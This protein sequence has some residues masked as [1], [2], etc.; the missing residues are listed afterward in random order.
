MMA[1]GLLFGGTQAWAAAPPANTVIGN[2]AT[3][4]YLD[5]NGVPQ[6]ATSNIV[7][8][9]VQQ[10]G[11][12]NLDGATQT[13]TTVQN[14]KTGAAGSV[15]YAPHVLTNTGNGTDTFVIKVDAPG[16]N[17]AS[18]GALSNISVFADANF[19]GLP[20]ST[21]ALCSVT[22]NPTGTCNVPAQS[23]AGNNGKFGFV[24]AY[25]LPGNVNSSQTPYAS[26]TITATPSTTA[27][28]TAPNT[29]ASNVDNINTTT[30]AAFNLVKAIQQPS[31]GINPPSGAWP[32]AV[33]TGKRSVAGANC[34][35]AWSSTAAATPGCQYTVY[36]LTYSNTGGAP[37][38]FV[39]KDVIGAG[40]T[41]GLQYVTGSAVWSGASGTALSEGAGGDPAGV[42]FAFDA[43]SKTLTFVD[44]TLPVSTPRSVSFVVLVT[45]TAPVGTTGTTNQAS[46]IAIDA[47]TATTTTPGTMTATSNTSP[48]TVLGSYSIAL[49]SASSSA[50]T[51]LDATAGTPNG[52]S[53][54]PFTAGADT[55][56]VPGA[57][58]GSSVAFSQ[59]VF[60]TGNDTDTVNITSSNPGTGGT[61]AFPAGT[62][63]S[64][65]K[66]D[67]ATQLNDSNGDGTV[68]TGPILA[69][70]STT[71]VVKAQ[72]PSTLAAAPNVNY[73]LTVIGRSAGD[74]SKSDTTRNVLTSV[75]GVL[76]DLTNSALG[77]SSGAGADVGMGP[78][79]SPTTT[80][81]VSAGATTVFPLYVKNNDSVNNTYALS[82]SGNATFPGT[83]P[84]GWTVKFVV[85]VVAPAACASAP[86]ITSVSVNAG[87]Q[88]QVSACVTPPLNQAVV[89]ASPLYFQVRSTGPASTGNTVVDTKYDAL[90][91]T[92]AALTYAATLTP[93]NSGQVA[94]G[95]S[96]VYAHTLTNT[97]SGV[98]TGAYDITATV[99]AANAGWTT[100]IYLDVNANGVLDASDT[101]VT[102][103]IAGPLVVGGTQAILV[104]VFAP[105]GAVAG[106]T[107]TATVTVTFPSGA[108]SCGAPSAK[109]LSTAVTGQIRLIK[110]QALDTAC[111]GTVG[112]QSAN[113]I[114][115]AKPGN[116]IVYQVTATNQGTSTVTNLMLSDTLPQY[117]T[118]NATQPSATC[119]STGITPA[120]GNGNY[121]TTAGAVSCGS[122]SNSVSAGGT[123]TLTF[124]VK[125][126]E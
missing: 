11:S 115:A 37:G 42:D 44:N 84:A 102:G 81:T 61:T 89:T 116:C 9:T 76:V 31:T 92:A 38:R 29:S 60:N 120:L 68:D 33:A 111:N 1:S 103:A 53:S 57:S 93:D 2:Q 65:Y 72:L 4:A 35:V 88:G 70:G 28:Y 91:V 15:V 101:L 79:A 104:K 126:N 114:L 27:L 30:A 19:D 119:A 22:P 109:D 90:T 105:G 47:P 125:V 25:S 50:V 124:E 13:S 98:C 117:T 48:F 3:A 118:L 82:V 96:V 8:T 55:T 20:D 41:A 67:G 74:T 49:G 64:Y 54:S 43:G 16:P 26:A 10:V 18:P 80:N 66:A 32:A 7:Q 77:T 83:L 71:I 121:S 34:P 56:I 112:T 39:M 6:S 59:T 106:E 23:V 100:A 21:T 99:P 95:G 108:T 62:T 85:G 5:P 52:G 17:P 69:G 36:T 75:T 94:N 97:G 86:A 24:V 14:A 45:D 107:S 63:F 51:A 73:V 113:P 87:D 78:S 40:S 12:F 110:T 46:F 123:A 122:A 58:A